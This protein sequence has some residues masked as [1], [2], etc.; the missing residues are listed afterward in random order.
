MEM[1]LLTIYI[2][3]NKFEC[4]NFVKICLRPYVYKLH[5]TGAILDAPIAVGYY[6]NV[7]VMNVR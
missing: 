4:D 6:I 7:L 5:Q 2:A 3:A 1:Q